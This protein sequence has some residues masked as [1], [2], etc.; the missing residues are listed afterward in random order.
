MLEVCPT[1]S[2]LSPSLMMPE[3]ARDM[4][5]CKRRTTSVWPPE[6]DV[7]QTRITVKEP[8]CSFSSSFTELAKVFTWSSLK[9]IKNEE[10]LEVRKH[11]DLSRKRLF[12]TPPERAQARFQNTNNTHSSLR[13]LFPQPYSFLL[14]KDLQ[15]SIPQLL[16][17]SVMSLIPISVLM[18]LF[19]LSE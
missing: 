18:T 17:C 2:F 7:A 16:H 19:A 10:C 1:F 4:A 6:G 9:T 11:P 12:Q 5:K 13:V 14:R 3:I 15:K 8:Q